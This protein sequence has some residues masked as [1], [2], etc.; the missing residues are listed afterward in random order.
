MD[1]KERIIT[2]SGK[3]FVT[4]GIRSVTMDS[5]SEEL[6][7]SKRTLYET[8][9]DKNTLLSEV[10][11]YHKKRQEAFADELVTNADNVIQAMVEIMKNSIE[12]MKRVNP[13]FFHDLKKYHPE[14]HEDIM[15]KG[16]IRNFS[17]TMKILQKGREQGIFNPELDLE[18][19][20]FTIH[21]L[22]NMFSDDTKFPLSEN[23]REVLWINTIRPY[24]KGISTEKGCKLIDEYML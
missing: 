14:I 6:G 1:L 15:N 21:A 19:V 9:V 24:M 5:I 10:L 3:M 7:I 4:Y 2:H 13:V 8:F 18:I 11:L 12:N 20:N 23:T 16:E 22:F 17:I